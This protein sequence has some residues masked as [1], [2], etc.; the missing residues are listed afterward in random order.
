M[1]CWSTAIPLIVV[2]PFP[3]NQVAKITAPVG[4]RFSTNDPTQKIM[5]PGNGPSRRPRCCCL[6]IEMRPES[7]QSLQAERSR[8]YTCLRRN[9][10]RWRGRSR[11]NSREKRTSEHLPRKEHSSAPQ[12]A[13]AGAK[14]ARSRDERGQRGIV[15]CL[16]SQCFYS[17]SGALRKTEALDRPVNWPLPAITTTR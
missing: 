12:R 15:T 16:S 14:Y 8:R 7:W 13:I 9:P 17:C 1:P 11:H 10:R 4:S 2:F 6:E 5:S 3:E